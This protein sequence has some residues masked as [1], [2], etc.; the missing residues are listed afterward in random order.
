LIIVEN[1]PVPFDRRVWM[2]ATTLRNAGYEVSII[3]PTGRGFEAKEEVLDGIRIYRHPLPAEGRSAKGFLREYASALR[4]E[5]RLARLVRKRHGI[6]AV[7]IC[8]PPDLL[9]LVAGW[10]KLVHRARVLF[11][12]H[13]INPEL[14]LAKYGRQDT[15]Y[16]L[17]RLAERAT[18]G[19][20]DVVVSTNESYREIALKRGRCD[21]PDVFVVRSAPDLSKFQPVPPVPTYKKGRAFLVGYLGVMGDQEGIDYLLRAAAD[22][23][24][25]QGRQDVQ[26]AL[27]GGGPVFEDLVSLCGQLKLDDFV[28]F[29]GRVPDSTLIECISTCDVCVNPDPSTP[30]NNLS[31]MNKVMEYMAM[32]KPIVQFDLV[33]GRRSA[34]EASLYAKVDDERDLA[35][36]IL[37]VLDNPDLRHEMGQIGRKRMEEQLEWRKQAPRLLEAYDRLFNDSKA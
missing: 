31:T 18:F 12:H 5:F 21:P 7:H 13:D 11:D 25:V 30:F 4:H 6:D 26:F 9:F 23:V 3:S 37:F 29:L 19:L 33:E 22:I 20:A 24:H 1:L 34:G 27:V 8:N 14:Y 2:E 36:K 16:R 10:L 32:S 15:F 35:D 17:L 28:D